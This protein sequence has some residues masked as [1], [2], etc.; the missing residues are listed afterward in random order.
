MTDYLNVHIR[1]KAGESE[2]DFKSRL[3]ELWTH[4]LRNHESEFEKVY[5]EASKFGR[6]GDRLVRQ[7]LFEAEIQEFLESQLKEKQF[8]YEAIDPD[9]IYTKYEASPPDWFQ[10]EH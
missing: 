4:L 5:A 3:S 7:Y 10:I 2:A 9:D 1:S 8:E 6:A